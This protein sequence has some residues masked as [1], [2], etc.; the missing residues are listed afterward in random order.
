M[1]DRLT[2]AKEM[3]VRAKKCQLSAKESKSE[4]FAECYRLLAQNYDMLASV[5]EKFLA[6]QIARGENVILHQPVDVTSTTKS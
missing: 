5:D 6:R 2:H 4:K 1:V 3:R